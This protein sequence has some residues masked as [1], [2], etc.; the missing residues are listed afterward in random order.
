MPASTVPAAKAALKALLEAW[1]FP[2]ASEGQLPVIRWGYPSEAEDRPPGGE[3]IV[4]GQTEINTTSPQLGNVRQDE[5]YTLQVIIEVRRY[6]DDE[7]ATEERAWDL[8][9]EV[10]TLLANEQKSRQPFGSPLYRLG[11][12]RIRQQNN[13][14]S[15]NQWMTQIIVDQGVT[16]LVAQ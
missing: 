16:G 6:G 14:A 8:Y 7:Q 13:V 15:Q 3:L 4:F 2:P 5:D 10:S 9:A 1:T 11:D 12:R